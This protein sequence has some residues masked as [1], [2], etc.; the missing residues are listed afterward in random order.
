MTA[1]EDANP[2]SGGAR[3]EPA[4]LRRQDREAAIAQESRIEHCWK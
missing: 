2:A 4:A 1:A 3:A